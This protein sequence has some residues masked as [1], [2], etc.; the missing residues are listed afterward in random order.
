MNDQK[1]PR[2]AL[3]LSGSV[4]FLN[5]F[6]I[7]F[8]N[9]ALPPIGSDLRGG[10]GDLAWIASSYLIVVSALLIPASRIADKFGTLRILRLGLATFAVGSLICAGAPNLL[11]MVGGR[12]IQATGASLFLTTGLTILLEAYPPSKRG[13]TL[14]ANIAMVYTGQ[15][16]GPWLG[17][18]VTD[19]WNWR[20][21]F[22]FISIGALTLAIVAGLLPSRNRRDG[23]LD[24]VGSLLHVASLV[25]IMAG[26]AMLPS[27]AGVTLLTFGTIT[28]IVHLRRASHDQT[29]L[30]S[31]GG[32]ANRTFLRGN[33]TQF[34][35]YLATF[36]VVFLLSIYLQQIRGLTA[37]ESG[38]LLLIAPAVQAVLSAPAGYLADRRH[39]RILIAG[40]TGLTAI[41][42]LAL[43]A[44]DSST[45]IA[46]IAGIQVALGVGFAVKSDEVV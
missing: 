22:M 26:L 46:A 3:I 40:G 38:A 34:L 5:P 44:I 16:L 35:Q 42:L 30:F 28:G 7:T 32:L 21:M 18:V 13:R 15:S 37:T 1:N 12:I 8:V 24:A 43:T 27:T 33:A 6:V 19:V 11:W 14:G 41:G 20:A 23:T 36:G 29:H 17:G 4:A 9:N 2:L 25:G 31:M 39:P 10:V 45:T